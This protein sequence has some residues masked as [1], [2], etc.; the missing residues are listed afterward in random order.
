MEEM[1]IMQRNENYKTELNV[2]VNMMVSINIKMAS[3]QKLLICYVEND[4][5]EKL[6]YHHRKL[7][8]Q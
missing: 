7:N 6:F 3:K 5:V 1:V 2:K 4:L 8:G